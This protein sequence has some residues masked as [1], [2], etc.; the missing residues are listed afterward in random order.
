MTYLAERRRKDPQWAKA[1]TEE[2]EN[3]PEITLTATERD[4]RQYVTLPSG[5]EVEVD[6]TGIDADQYS[7]AVVAEFDL[8]ET[9]IL[10]DG[11][12]VS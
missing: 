1:T 7:D 2:I 9:V 12:R 4:G 3:T 5:T 11:T 8:V 6:G 10:S